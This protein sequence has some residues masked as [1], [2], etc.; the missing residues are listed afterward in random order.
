[1]NKLNFG[2]IEV[3]K[4]KFYESKKAI[5]LNSVDVVNI[6]VSNKIKGNKET[7]KYFIGYMADIDV[8]MRLCIMSLCI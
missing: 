3:S 5:K 4:K 6:A 1:M 8:V 7:S 2:D